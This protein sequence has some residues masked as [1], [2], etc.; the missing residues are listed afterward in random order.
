M[1]PGDLVTLAAVKAWVSP[2]KAT[3]NQ[4]ALLS[5]LIR[6]ASQ[7]VTNY[8]NRDS[9][10]WGEI[11]EIRDGNDLDFMVL[12]NCPAV[13][14]TSV[15]LGNGTILTTASTGSPPSNGFKLDPPRSS[16]QRVVLNGYV[17]PRGRS[18]ITITYTSGYRMDAESHVVEANP[19][20]GYTVEPYFPWIEDLGVTL[21]GA[22]MTKVSGAPA[23]GQ[24][25]V[26]DGVYTFNA[27]QNGETVLISYSQCPDDVAQAVIELVGERYKANSRIG[28]QS[29]SMGGSAN[30]TVSF[31]TKDFNDTIK[32][33][34]KP[35]RMVTPA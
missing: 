33:F 30:V 6:A 27:A 5:R 11:V 12:R 34:L 17:F 35:Y 20:G 8:C 16:N 22:A 14:V 24:Y 32:T 13:S 31:S 10:A 7:A 4:D 15:D 28:E 25:A 3:T 19:E 29:H 2:G 23:A 1:A 9:F 21:N 18:N 26:S